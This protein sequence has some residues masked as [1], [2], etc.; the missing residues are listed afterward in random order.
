MHGDVHSP[1]IS[2][3]ASNDFA[4][5]ASTTPFFF[6]GISDDLYLGASDKLYSPHL[7][8]THSASS[9]PTLPP[10]T[11]EKVFA[12]LQGFGELI[13]R[14]RGRPY[15]STLVRSF[16]IAIYLCFSCYGCTV[17]KFLSSFIQ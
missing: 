14:K 5:L 6:P 12:D 1:I 2:D 8:L 4:S 10:R 9:R 7:L 11:K 15:K 16:F 13:P 17:A 3:F